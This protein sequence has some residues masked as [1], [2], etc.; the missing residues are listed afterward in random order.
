MRVCVCVYVF[1]PYGAVA[2]AAISNR[3]VAGWIPDDYGHT[4]FFSFS[5]SS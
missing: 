2:C 5:D 3:E 1:V 4:S